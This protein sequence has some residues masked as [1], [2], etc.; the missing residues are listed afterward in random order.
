MG[1][2]TSRNYSHKMLF[3][4]VALRKMFGV[5][6]Y[7]T[8]YAFNHVEDV[9]HELRYM[10]QKPAEKFPSEDVSDYPACWALYSCSLD[11]DY[12]ASC[13]WSRALENVYDRNRRLALNLN[14]SWFMTDGNVGQ[15][16]TIDSC[17]VL[18][19]LTD[20]AISETQEAIA[21]ALYADSCGASTE[22]AV[23]KRDKHTSS[24]SGSKRKKSTGSK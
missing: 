11:I 6:K 24:S 7:K 3:A 14:W 21:S 5:T 16:G 9:D 13:R 23:E 12:P 22:V 19:L 2:W 17:I 18:G 15:Y 10:V 1:S 20:G 4:D 8:P